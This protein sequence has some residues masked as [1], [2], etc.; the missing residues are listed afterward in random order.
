MPIIRPTSA[1][2]IIQMN[3]DFI[4][5]LFLGGCWTQKFAIAEFGEGPRTTGQRQ[6]FGAGHQQFVERGQSGAR[7]T[8][9][10]GANGGTVGALWRTDGYRSGPG[11]LF[12]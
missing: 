7:A 11:A 6:R 12:E 3:D 10:I 1:S 5:L 4:M 2:S 9:A 8:T